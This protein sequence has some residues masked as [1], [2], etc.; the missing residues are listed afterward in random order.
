[1]SRRSSGLGLARAGVLL[2]AVLLPPGAVG[3]AQAPA[4]RRPPGAPEAPVAV[5]LPPPLKDAHLDR[6][7]GDWVGQTQAS[8]V[9]YEVTSSCA[10]VINGQFLRMDQRAWGPGMVVEAVWFWRP[11]KEGYTGWSFNSFG[12]Q[13]SAKAR[14]EGDAFV[15]TSIDGHGN[16]T[17]TTSRFVGSDEVVFVEESGPDAEAKYRKST[18]GMYRR[19]KPE[20]GPLPSPPPSTTPLP[21]GDP[22]L[23]G[24]LGRWSGTET[25]LEGGRQIAKGFEADWALGRQFLLLRFEARPDPAGAPFEV[26]ALWHADAASSGVSACSFDANGEVSV[27]GGK[28]EGEMLTLTSD[29]PKYGARRTHV[30]RKGPEE[31][32]IVRE[33]DAERD[34]SYKK[35]AEA[36]YRR[37]K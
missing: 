16:P 36:I 4:G 21:S 7:V 20:A 11:T 27:V 10:W 34:G 37:K 35:V 28:S 8:G 9:T 24:L 15:M 26:L 23:A 19:A 18:E 25:Y 17:R 29:D 2:L 33:Q 13:A 32:A 1:M 31:F 5:T 22:W 14:L 30:V 6:L 12:G 3:L